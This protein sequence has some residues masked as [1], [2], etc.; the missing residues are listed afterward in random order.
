MNYEVD[1]LFAKVQLRH[2]GSTGKF[3]WIRQ[4]LAQ[5]VFGPFLLLA[6]KRS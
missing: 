1:V 6:S 5:A 2:A 3:A 4:K